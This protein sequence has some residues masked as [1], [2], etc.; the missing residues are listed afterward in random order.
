MFDIKG[1][2][3]ENKEICHNS[4]SLKIKPDKDII[5]SGNI[6]IEGNISF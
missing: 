2:N 1:F 4:K 3:L 5:I 6:D